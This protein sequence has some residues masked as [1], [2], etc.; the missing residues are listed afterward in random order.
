MVEIATALASI[1]AIR[2]LGG[3]LLTKYKDAETERRVHEITAKL[4]DVQDKLHEL[5][6]E[7]IAL[8]EEKRQVAEKLR[9]AEERGTRRSHYKLVKTPGG[10]QLPQFDGHDGSLKHYVCP[11]CMETRGEFHPL[12]DLQNRAG[13]HAC[14]ACKAHYRVDRPDPEPSSVEPRGDW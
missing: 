5:R 12:Q 6:E 2:E 3:W 14:P 7:N 13:T 4:G 1:K 8:L 10:A 9:V 11:A